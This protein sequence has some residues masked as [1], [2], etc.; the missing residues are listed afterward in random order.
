MLD[1]NPLYLGESEATLLENRFVLY[2]LNFL[3]IVECD[4]ANSMLVHIDFFFVCERSNTKRHKE[5]IVGNV[6]VYLIRSRFF[7]H[8]W[9]LENEL[10][11]LAYPAV[12]AEVIASH[13]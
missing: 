10:V 8:I 2:C 7:L 11:F 13:I 3:R 12:I 4:G 1:Y 9:G 5:N 6:S